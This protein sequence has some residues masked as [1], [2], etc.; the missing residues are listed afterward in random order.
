MA[1][2]AAP[3]RA[4]GER[5]AMS[6]VGTAAPGL[7]ALAL[8]GCASITQ[9]TAS[10]VMLEAR[11]CETPIWCDIANKK[12]TLHV[13]VPGQVT[14]RKSD[15]PLKITCRTGEGR[16][17]WTGTLH[18]IDTGRIWGN[19]LL[20]GGAIG[21]IIDAN[22]DAHWE[23][24]EHLNIPACEGGS[25]RL[26]AAA[27]DAARSPDPVAGGAGGAEAGAGGA[28][29]GTY[30]FPAGHAY[31]GARYTGELHAGLPHGRGTAAFPAGHADE[32]FRHEGEFRGGEPHGR[33]TV[34][35]AH[36]DRYAGEF[37]AGVLHG[38][39]A[40][41]YAN[42]DRFE[43]EYRAGRRHGLGTYTYVSGDRYEGEYHAGRRHGRGTY[44]YFNGD[45][46]VGE[47]RDDKPH[48]WGTYIHADGA[49]YEGKWR[50]GSRIE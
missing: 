18:G 38:R 13:A 21:A 50:D 7:I 15:D 45:R 35:Y 30:T 20:P 14:I 37:S 42:G 10:I 23:Y 41:T 5:I 49:S 2:R 19:A 8:G 9:P 26:P 46:Y 47:F 17:L 40:Y 33:G 43:G 11:G 36:G 12:E 16:P 24:P 22:T 27:T 29:R 39:G 1:A 4:A 48:G 32:G 3:L 31:A 6:R 25:P 34:V 28:A 44:T